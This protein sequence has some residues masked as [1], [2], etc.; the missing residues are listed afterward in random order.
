M[1]CLKP[2]TS[3]FLAVGVFQGMEAVISPTLRSVMSKL[4]TAQDQGGYRSNHTALIFP[5]SVKQLMSSG[6]CMT[7]GDLP[8]L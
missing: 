5:C 6:R 8:Y 3:F 4:V 1:L 7:L 2:K